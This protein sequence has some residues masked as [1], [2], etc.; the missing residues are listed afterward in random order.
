LGGKSS[1]VQSNP[2]EERFPTPQ[3]P[4]GMT[5][6]GKRR[7]GWSSRWAGQRWIKPG[8]LH[9]MARR[10]QAARKK[11]TGHSGRD[12]SVSR[13]Q[14]N[15]RPTRKNGVWGTRRERL[16]RR[17]IKTRTSATSS[18]VQKAHLKD[19]GCG[20]RPPLQN[21][22][23]TPQDSRTRPALHEGRGNGGGWER[24]SVP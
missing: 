20:T 11:R 14:E 18:G 1:R 13:N 15:P 12:D 21:A 10:A 4:F 2:R 7:I 19:K 22:G 24:R 9:C 3:T 17:K 8:S 6:G 5:E 16:E 23:E